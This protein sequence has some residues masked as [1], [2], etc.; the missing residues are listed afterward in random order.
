MADRAILHSDAN[1][2]YASVEMALDPGL[3]GKAVAVCGSPEERHGIV[4][5]KSDPAKKAGVKTGMANWQARQLCPDLIVLPPQYEY[6][7]KY[8]N[9]L[10]EIYSRY[11][12]LIEPF[13]MDEC[14]LDVT[15]CRYTPEATA[16]LIRESVK[17]ELGITVSVG[18]SFNKVF[19]KLGSDMKKPDAVTV[20]SR[21]NF[22][23]KIWPLPADDMIYIGRATIKKLN[24][25]GIYTIGDVAGASPDFLRQLFGVN[26]LSMWNYANGNDKSRVSNIDYHAPVKSIGH[27]ITCV[28]DL[29]SAEEVRRV[30]LELSQDIGHRL[31][32]LNLAATGV[33]VTVRNKDLTFLQFQGKLQMKTQLPSEMAGEAYRLFRNHYGE[34][35]KVR[36]VTVRAIDLVSADSAEQLNAF[37][38]FER[39]DKLNRIQD[40]VEL[41]RDKYGSRALTYGSLMGDLKMPNDKR[42][43]VK[44]PGIMNK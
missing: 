36:A 24:Y 34:S 38:D 19:A 1:S 42:E 21:E 22:R 12:D 31:R 23:E 44:M 37:D 33:Q 28:T 8:S 11:T 7:V 27:G 6:Y 32:V 29:D 18:V 16:E 20:I 17:D 13:G 25:Y 40:A 14:W 43:M 10:H 30:M 15:D 35:C 4:L 3:K 2:F 41:V 39:R 5:A 9:M 26:G